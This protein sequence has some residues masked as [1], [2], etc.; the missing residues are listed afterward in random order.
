[1]AAK[2]GLLQVAIGVVNFLIFVLAFTSIWPFP[3][4]DFR[5]DLPEPNEVEWSYDEGRVHITAPYS[6]DN[7]GFYDVDDLVVSYSVTNSTGARIASDSF[8]IGALPAGQITSGRLDF[9]LNLMQLYEQGIVWMIFNDDW[10]N[11][12]I[13]VSCLYTMGLVDFDALY[14]VTVPWDALVRDLELEDVSLDPDGQGLT[15]HY[16]LETS[17]LLDGMSCGLRVTYLDNG[18]PVATAT[19]NVVL[20]Q[21]H[22]SIHLDISTIV[23]PDGGDTLQFQVELDGL[24]VEQEMEVPL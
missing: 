10:L 12:K 14:R 17:P 16:T 21:V 5:I 6:V 4:G 11:L 19:Q 18:V 8:E 20:G 15:V 23:I 7:G 24:T 3:N 2:V 22:Y 9:Y 13:S 1:M